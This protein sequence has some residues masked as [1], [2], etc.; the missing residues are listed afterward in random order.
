MNDLGGKQGTRRKKD[1]VPDG[2]TV[3]NKRV[4]F[5]LP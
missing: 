3:R 5:N 4:R 2:G 1:Y